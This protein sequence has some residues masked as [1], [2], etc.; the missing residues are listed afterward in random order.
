MDPSERIDQQ[1]AALPDW[2][3]P[4]FAQLRQLIHAAAPEIREEW[5]WET[6]VFVHQGNVCAVAPFKDRLK[7]NF[8]QGARLLDPQ[9]LFNAGLEAKNTRAI[10]FSAG[11]T[12][13]EAALQALLRAA[14]AQNTTKR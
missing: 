2:R 13:Q 6:A 11:D 9:G 5:K 1:I 14:V 3:G 8:F 7:L 4:L 12:L 10:D